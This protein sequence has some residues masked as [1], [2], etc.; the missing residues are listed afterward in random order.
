MIHQNKKSVVNR[1]SVTIWQTKKCLCFAWWFLQ[2]HVSLLCCIWCFV[3]ELPHS[4]WWFLLSL[5]FPSLAEW[6]LWSSLILSWMQCR[7][8]RPWSI[9]GC[10]KN[11]Q[12]VL[13]SE[14]I[15][16][17]IPIWKI[18]II[19]TLIGCCVWLIFVKW[20]INSNQQEIIWGP[21]ICILL[22][23]GP[24]YCTKIR[25]MEEVCS[26]ISVSYKFYQIYVTKI[27]LL[28]LH[29]GKFQIKVL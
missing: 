26:I 19:S 12:Q 16:F 6:A 14:F 18:T 3:C 10:E 5:L 9:Y 24:I 20:I 25:V 28:P 22:F 13:T 15:E 2:S 4:S 21:E 29:S 11:T 8:C 7:K 23:Y 1:L 17:F 27:S